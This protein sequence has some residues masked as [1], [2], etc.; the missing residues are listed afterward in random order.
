MTE[1]KP[2]M[3]F[4]PKY[5]DLIK[6]ARELNTDKRI[7]GDIY[8]H[9]VKTNNKIIIKNIDLESN[10]PL[11]A[12]NSTKQGKQNWE[13][14]WLEA[15]IINKSKRGN[16]E[17]ATSDKTYRFLSSQLR[18][19]SNDALKGHVITDVL[20]Y[21]SVKGHLVIWELKPNAYEESVNTAICELNAYC[22]ELTRLFI[23][24]ETEKCNARLAYGLENDE[25]RKV[26]GYV[27][28]PKN[29]KNYQMEQ[30]GLYEYSC[31]GLVINYGKLVEPWKN[32]S[33]SMNIN[34]ELK[35]EP[36]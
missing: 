7:A 17:F 8:F 23:G 14:H 11:C 31:T 5:R 35:G 12:V 24:D 34:F 32:Y 1:K 36:K 28:L 3:L 21:D 27:V 18:F 19:H 2:K 22:T 9:P 15:Y 20:F 29:D 4:T 16:W 30:F 6:R 10:E 25:I 26:D 13:E 33:R